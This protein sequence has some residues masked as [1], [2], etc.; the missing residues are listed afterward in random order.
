MLRCH[1]RDFRVLPLL[2]C[3][4]LLLLAPRMASAQSE[5]RDASMSTLQAETVKPAESLCKDCALQSV[6][7]PTQTGSFESAAQREMKEAASGANAVADLAADRMYLKTGPNA[8]VEVSNPIAGQS[9]YVHFDWRNIGSTN[10]LGFLLEVRLNGNILCAGN[11]NANANTVHI[12]WCSEALTWPSGS[13]TISAVLD[14]NNIIAETNENNNS[15]SRT[16]Q[17]TPTDPDINV[18]PTALTINQTAAA[19]ANEFITTQKPR[20]DFTAA[21]LEH[22][23][24]VK[25]RANAAV[26]PIVEQGKTFIGLA[27][28]DIRL[29]QFGVSE[30]ATIFRGPNLPAYLKNT[31]K[32]RIADAQKLQ[33]AA[34]ELSRLDTIE[35]VDLNYLYKVSDTPNDPQY[36]QQWHLP[37]VKAAEAWDLGTGDGSV[38]IAIIDTGVDWDHPDLAANIWA[39]PHET[40][41]NDIDDD[42]NGYIRV[43][44]NGQPIDAFGFKL[45]VD[46]S[47]FAFVRV[48]KGDLTA[49]FIAINAQ[50]NPAGS[51]TITCG[52][53]GIT[54][55]PANSAG[56]L[57]RLCFK[58]ICAT[59]SASDLVLSAPADDLL[60]FATCCNRF[61]CVT[62]VRDGD[63]N[64]DLTLTPGDALAIFSRYLQNLPPLECFAR[65]NA[66]ATAA[67]A[68]LQLSFTSRT[69]VASE[70][71]QELVKVALRAD[72]PEGLQAL[73]LQL[74]YPEN[75]LELLGV[76]RSALTSDWIQLEGQKREHGV[77]RIGGFNDKPI[78]ANQS[79]EL[80][81]I[82]FASKG[83]AINLSDFTL[84]DLVDDF[85]Q[86]QVQNVSTSVA[87]PASAPAVF[88]LHQ[89]YPNPFQK[90]THNSEMI[91]RFDLP[92]AAST[93]V[94][95]A[96]Y[97]LAGQ[98]VRHLI[99]G[100]RQPGAYE[101]RWD[102]R[103][104]S[105]QPVPS[106]KYLYR[107]KAGKLAESKQL[108]IVR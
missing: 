45:Q 68:P 89:S 1:E 32:I 54:A 8:G 95:L 73:G 81:E 98:L 101:V 94:E 20:R 41:N 99:S 25:F 21:H 16:Y 18:T 12:A 104:E 51:G 11:V 107:L 34:E 105:G 14:V 43:K 59:I 23:L 91:I 78:A 84:T 102:G 37:K 47:Q 82:V 10:A 24:I 35:W 57:L 100:E 17:E 88:K 50:E 76:T 31:F 40:A 79:D 44:Q 9:C 83:Q 52:G 7:I 90:G 36:L 49:D 5:V 56:V 2:L 39:N 96:V 85:E 42:G 65:T 69:V 4:V 87:A 53:F 22:E 66:I 72:H 67:R 19:R 27:T 3:S 6:Q 70:N 77:V 60:G 97:N 15:V 30:M 92:G 62:C 55:I 80:L 26:Q 29:Q 13:N 61:E 46:P 63:V 58:V 64:G 74:R 93:P 103:N 108:T 48:E 38:V 75:K 71:N 86:A 106:G 33:E 28:I